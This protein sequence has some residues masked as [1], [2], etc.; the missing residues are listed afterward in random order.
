VGAVCWNSTAIE[1]FSSRG[2]TIGGDT[3]PDLSGPD[4]VSTKTYGAGTTCSSGGFAGTS[5]AAPHVAG[6]AALVKGANP[7]YS[8]T[9][10][11]DYLEAQAKDLGS[12]GLDDTF[13]YGLLHLPSLAVVPPSAPTGVH[14]VGYNLSALIS[15]TASSNNGGSPITKYTVTSDPEGRTCTT[16][17][18]LSCKVAGLTNGTPY[19]FTVR[20][21]NTA[22]D[23]PASAPSAEITPNPGAPLAPAGVTATRGDLSASVSWTAADSNGSP[24]TGYRVTSTPGGKTCTWT[25]GPLSCVVN[26][27]TNGT[28]YTFTVRATNVLGT[29]P[30][31]AASNSVTP[32][33]L[34]SAPS[35]LSVI[36][37]NQSVLVSWQAASA[38][39]AA[40][41]L[42]TVTA[43]P[44]GMTCT[45]TGALSCTVTGLANETGYT[46]T[47]R[48]T[49]AVGTGPVSAMST[50]ATPKAVPDAPTNLTAIGLDGSAAVSWAAPASN[51]SPISNYTVTS[52]PGGFSCPPT[53]PPTA[54]SCT[55]LGLTN[56]TA[57]AFT[58]TAANAI[59]TGP[60]SAPAA[61][62]P[63]SGSTYHPVAP[64]RLLDTRGAGIGL[65]GAFTAGH[66]RT[67]AVWGATVP[68]GAVGVTGNLTVTGQT[69]PGYLFLGPAA[70]NAP[71]SSTLNFP[72][73]DNR[74]N[75]VTVALSPAGTLS[76]TYVAAAGKTA[77]VIFDV[78]GYFTQ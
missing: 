57:Y 74:A 76:V 69:G 55:V 51:G 48:A 70:M 12:A 59:G 30:A 2:P 11:R 37:Y 50:S 66:A 13:G 20:A 41:V 9:D 31:S 21:T 47:A 65:A 73:G 52:S 24:I 78:T 22:G 33:G 38:N 3:K 32:A 61:A 36:P 56:R 63:L 54:T 53:T 62:T 44:G 25:T 46:F 5:A 67:F 68:S 19:T 35:S 77:H 1:S 45:T 29:G 58:V 42:Y 34:P 8:A 71:T 40:I 39:G 60:A 64:A 43:A 16:T 7:S 17:G 49:N 23:G 14:G 15:W 27:L 26:G 75:G 10:I 18:A 6:A 72:L 4:R 28:A